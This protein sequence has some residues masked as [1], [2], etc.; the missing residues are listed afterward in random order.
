[1]TALVKAARQEIRNDPSWLIARKMWEVQGIIS[2]VKRREK[3]EDYI[4]LKAFRAL[5]EHLTHPLTVL[6]MGCGYG[7]FSFLLAEKGLNVT[8]IDKDPV[9]IRIANR[10]RKYLGWEN[11]KFKKGTIDTVK[12]KFDRIF[13][14]FVLHDMVEHSIEEIEK[15]RAHLTLQGKIIILDY[16]KGFEKL[17]SCYTVHVLQELG[18]ASHDGVELWN[19][20]LVELLE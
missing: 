9:A 4:G 14:G 13:Y 15:A 8:G 20:Y 7:R 5:T 12:G 16:E 17:K 10:A 6:D 3:K 11:L 2:H 19:V 1:M 18:K